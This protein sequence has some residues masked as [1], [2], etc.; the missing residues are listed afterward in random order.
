M[1]AAEA[2]LKALDAEFHGPPEEYAGHALAALRSALNADSARLITEPLFALSLAAVEHR[3]EPGWED[4]SQVAKAA[5]EDRMFT[6]ELTGRSTAGARTPGE[7]Q[8]G[9]VLPISIG[10]GNHRWVMECTWNSPRNLTSEEWT[11]VAVVRSF[12]SRAIRQQRR[13]GIAGELAHIL[14]TS[15]DPRSALEDIARALRDHLGADGVKVVVVT[16]KM[17]RLAHQQIVRTGWDGESRSLWL[18]AGR[19]LA[20]HVLETGRAVLVNHGTETLGPAH[21]MHADDASFVSVVPI[22]EGEFYGMPHPEDRERHQVLVPL[23]H[24]GRCAGVLGVWRCDQDAHQDDLDALTVLA[25]LAASACV[26]IG[27]LRAVTDQ[28]TAAI[29]LG[30]M[31]PH[32]GTAATLHELLRYLDRISASRH[33]V[34]FAHD[35]ER[36][37][38]LY[39]RHSWSATEEDSA[40][41][42]SMRGTHLALLP[43]T[44]TWRDG[45]SA[46]IEPDLGSVRDVVLLG[47]SPVTHAIVL[48]DVAP[49]GRLTMFDAA[50]RERTQ[51]TFLKVMG[52]V[53]PGHFQARTLAAVSEF[54]GALAGCKD[55][56]EVLHALERHL[57]RHLPGSLALVYA[58]RAGQTMSLIAPADHTIASV[59][60][61][62]GGLAAWAVECGQA[63]LIRDLLDPEAPLR[64]K[65]D[66]AALE[67]IQ[68]HLGW[69]GVRSFIA[70]PIDRMGVVKALTPN[71]GPFL[72]TEDLSLVRAL[73]DEAA[74]EATRVHREAALGKLNVL[75]EAL[76]EFAG[77]RLAGKLVLGLEA[78]LTTVLGTPCKVAIFAGSRPGKPFLEAAS[79]GLPRAADEL[80]VLSPKPLPARWHPTPPLPR[81][82]IAVALGIAGLVGELQVFADAPL[83]LGDLAWVQQAAREVSV[84]LHAEQVA[85]DWRMYDGVFR[86]ALLGPVQGLTSAARN[87][88]ALSEDEATPE[89]RHEAMSRVGKEAEAIRVW[90]ET[91]RALGPLRSNMPLRPASRDVPVRPL[92]ERATRRYADAFRLERGSELRLVTPAGSLIVHRCD[93]DLLDLVVCNLLENAVK[94]SFRGR[95]A[96]IEAAVEG[97]YVAIRVANVGHPIPEDRREAVYLPY[98]RH[99]V[100]PVRSIRG[101]GLG[102]FVSRA[103]VK[104]LGGTLDHTSVSQGR[105]VHPGIEP[106]HTVFTLRIPH[107]WRT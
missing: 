23:L 36:P 30:L 18:E 4:A 94:Y 43:D 8:S 82:G 68:H 53:L 86:H 59:P 77:D 71:T 62:P 39:Y 49:P 6:F 35:P 103:I 55:V 47:E 28:D 5:A 19:G 20:A 91:S 40:K 101:E 80:S 66:L 32:A 81:H 44:E 38:H 72:S 100:D 95:E 85:E 87:L 58:G 31:D 63:L 64:S 60:V 93:A 69:Q 54:R 90:H 97:P 48:I 27:D 50:V 84:L 96:S 89:E 14:A 37:G 25:P 76:T 52:A 104:A 102:L 34:I 12:V 75:S 1:S 10:R 88:V 70:S 16:R 78:W 33:A 2:V 11:L 57:N 79:A 74:T 7:A 29:L 83:G 24:D 26:R 3:N 45:L 107:R 22:G 105:P 65:V 61:G 98:G 21:C 42:A 17:G 92:L 46:M 41:L 99:T 73:C 56:G 51:R 106:H 13:T 15:T 9:L 67:A